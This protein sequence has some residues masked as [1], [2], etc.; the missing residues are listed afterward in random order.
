MIAGVRLVGGGGGAAADHLPQPACSQ[1]S[2]ATRG[3][4]VWCW[5][6]AHALAGRWARLAWWSQCGSSEVVGIVVGA[7]WVPGLLVVVSGHHGS[8]VL[9][10]VAGTGGVCS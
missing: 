8:T 3:Q 6:P 4:E 10:W 2:L 7:L 9:C 1:L 5:E